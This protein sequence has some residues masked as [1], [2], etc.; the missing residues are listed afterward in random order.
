MGLLWR[1]PDD[2]GRF[3]RHC[4]TAPLRGLP[5]AATLEFAWPNTLNVGDYTAIGV[6]R[7]VAMTHRHSPIPLPSESLPHLSLFVSINNDGTVTLGGARHVRLHHRKRRRYGADQ[8]R[9]RHHS[10]SRYGGQIDQRLARALARRVPLAVGHNRGGGDENT[11]RTDELA[12]GLCR[13]H[14]VRYLE[15]APVPDCGRIARRDRHCC[16][17]AR[18]LGPERDDGDDIHLSP[19]GT[20]TV[21]PTTAC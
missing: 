18:V 13:A 9:R 15:S 12:V 1:N 19:T 11:D 21:G 4:G 8:R 6:L 14:E 20:G 5:T 3:D 16:H 10:A 2:R 17:G 7:M